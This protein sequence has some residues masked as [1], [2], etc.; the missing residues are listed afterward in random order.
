MQ[1]GLDIIADGCDMKQSINQYATADEFQEYGAQV[2]YPKN[3]L[4]RCVSCIRTADAASGKTTQNPD[5]RFYNAKARARMKKETTL[6]N[7][8]EQFA[9]MMEKREAGV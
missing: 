1:K 5:L 6:K 7:K 2:G 4:A 8:R 9:A 3:I